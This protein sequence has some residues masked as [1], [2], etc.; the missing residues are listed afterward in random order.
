MTPTIWRKLK[1]ETS[2]PLTVDSQIMVKYVEHQNF[3]VKYKL[4][5]DAIGTARLPRQGLR[6]V[7]SRPLAKSESLL[8]TLEG[9]EKGGGGCF[10]PVGSEA[11]PQEELKRQARILPEVNLCTVLLKLAELAEIWLIP[12][13]ARASALPGELSAGIYPG[14]WESATGSLMMEISTAPTCSHPQHWHQ[15]PAERE[16][17]PV[18][19]ILFLLTDVS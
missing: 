9:M 6:Q 7:V 14:G 8:R 17:S 1:S 4:L 5:L 11:M 19:H 3:L 13:Y 18:P 10:I 2:N 15:Q 16:C 12:T